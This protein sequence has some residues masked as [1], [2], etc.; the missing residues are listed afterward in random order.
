MRIE[1]HGALREAIDAA[2]LRDCD[3]GVPF[4]YVLFQADCRLS[5]QLIACGGFYRLSE[6][7]E[8]A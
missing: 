8:S 6:S 3:A 2:S 1:E 4:A 7:F 5:L